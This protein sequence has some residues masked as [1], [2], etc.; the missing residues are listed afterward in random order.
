MTL[1]NKT[2]LKLSL[3]RQSADKPK[4]AHSKTEESAAENTSGVIMS[5]NVGS[6][7]PIYVKIKHK[8][9]K[10]DAFSGIVPASLEALPVLQ[11]I[12]E[13]FEVNKR[14]PLYKKKK[15]YSLY[16]PEQLCDPELRICRIV[17]RQGCSLRVQ[18]SCDEFRN[19]HICDVSDIISPYP[20]ADF[21]VGSYAIGRII[22]DK[23]IC[24]RKTIV[25]NGF[26][27]NMQE[28]KKN[29]TLGDYRA[30]IDTFGGAS[31]KVDMLVF[32]YVKA[33][34]EKGCFISIARNFDVR[35]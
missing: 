13:H 22:D 35:V 17:S 9:V 26:P 12:P 16:P 19:C 29:E 23:Y 10:I 34:T 14:V 6:I 7:H 20:L 25:V 31:L 28:C 30:R 1:T 15:G 3:S 11:N 2:Y 18:I 32:G 24:L 27:K 33:C 4:T 21:N 5:V 8:L